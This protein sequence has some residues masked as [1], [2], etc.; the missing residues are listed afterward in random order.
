M[1]L[2]DFVINTVVIQYMQ[3]AEY[4]DKKLHSYRLWDRV[5][6][7]WVLSNWSGLTASDF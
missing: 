2:V 1:H 5:I 4:E 3:N 6:S 7:R